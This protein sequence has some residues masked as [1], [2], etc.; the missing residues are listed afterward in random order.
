MKWVIDTLRA[1]G[2]L[3]I[4]VGLPSFVVFPVVALLMVSVGFIC[5]AV[6]RISGRKIVLR[7]WLKPEKPAGPECMNFRERQKIT[8]FFSFMRGFFITNSVLGFGLWMTRGGSMM[9]AACLPLFLLSLVLVVESILNAF[10][11]MKRGRVSWAYPLFASGLLYIVVFVF[12]RLT[13]GE[14]SE[15]LGFG[16]VVSGLIALTIRGAAASQRA[17]R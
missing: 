6:V 11:F 7:R 13:P 5:V 3:C 8:M 10:G 17:R 15:T 1:A 14:P 9:I 4:T 2:I 16:A 12:F